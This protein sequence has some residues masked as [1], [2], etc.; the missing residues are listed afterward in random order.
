MNSATQVDNLIANW[1]RMGLSKA[2]IVVKQA[3]AMLGWPYVW[4]ATGQDCTPERRTYFMNRSAI[5]DGDRNLIIKRCQVLNGSHALCTGCKYYPGGART[6][7]QD[8]QGFMKEIFKTVG[9]TLK[10]GGCTSMYADNSNWS[11]KGPISEMP[12]G[13]VCCVFKHVASTGKMDHVGLHIGG[14][15]I[16]HCSGEVKRGNT[17]EKGWTHYAI[18]AGIDGEVEP[19]TDKPTL[20]RGSKGEYVTLL[21]TMLIQRGYDVGRWGVDGSFG[22]GTESAV[23]L[24]QEDNGLVNDGIVGQKTW[25]A[26]ESGQTEMYT[27]TVQH[28]SRTVAEAIIGQYGGVMTAE[29]RD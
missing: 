6:R 7:I 11:A 5:G 22:A 15:Q 9:I 20:R 24:F 26:L 12:A 3:E 10:G 14:G 13:A 29:G 17:S 19:T 25:A 8:C 16:I 4:G 18:P 2:E 28:V 1:K 27:V 23:K 21:Q